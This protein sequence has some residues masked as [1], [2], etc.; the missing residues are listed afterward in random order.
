MADFIKVNWNNKACNRTKNRIR[1]HGPIFRV[2]DA[3]NSVWCMDG[4]SALLLVSQTRHSS[5]GMGG[6]EHWTGWLPL[7]EID[8]E[9]A[10]SDSMT[11]R[12]F[13]VR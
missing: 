10:F 2:A 4:R 3:R 11:G 8:F 5:N 6:R 12:T 13:S 7:D 9:P 1:E